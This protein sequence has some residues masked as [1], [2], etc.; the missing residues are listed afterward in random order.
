MKQN[1]CT[2]P[3]SGC[4]PRGVRPPERRSV[5]SGGSVPPATLMARSRAA[6]KHQ[7]HDAREALRAARRRVVQ[8]EDAFESWR[9]LEHQL[10]DAGPVA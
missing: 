8:L 9:W 5:V 4:S 6:A 7:L 3:R 2:D 1:M 10:V